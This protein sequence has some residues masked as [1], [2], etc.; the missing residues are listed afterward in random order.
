MVLKDFQNPVYLNVLLKCVSFVL[1]ALNVEHFCATCL[2]N[3]TLKTA[4]T[5]DETHDS[6]DSK[7]QI[8]CGG[9]SLRLPIN[10]SKHDTAHMRGTQKR[11]K[12]L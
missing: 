4:L 2:T 1:D 8:I 10:E 9:L 7:N 3:H 11:E 6:T 12:T 5:E